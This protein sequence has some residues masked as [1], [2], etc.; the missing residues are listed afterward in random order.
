MYN[1]AHIVIK[2]SAILN[3]E[4]YLTHTK[5]ITFEFNILSIAFHIAQANINQ[6]LKSNSLLFLIFFFSFL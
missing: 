2:L 6:K 4:K 3:I 5:S 1:I